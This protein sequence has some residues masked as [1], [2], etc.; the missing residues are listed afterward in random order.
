MQINSLQSTSAAQ[1]VQRTLAAKPA[2]PV[3]AAPAVQSS[4]TDQL[5]LSAEAQALGQTQSVGATQ[6]SDGIRTEKVAALRQAIANG[7]YETP[8]KLSSALDKMLDT[9]A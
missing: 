6:S 8:E 2:S 4:F 5:D 1:T 7:S 3:Q 9:F